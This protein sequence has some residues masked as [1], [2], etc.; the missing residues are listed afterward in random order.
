[1]NDKGVEVKGTITYSDLQNVKV[2]FEGSVEPGTYTIAV[3]TRSG[4]GGEYGV[5]RATR[6]VVVK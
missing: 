2:V 4:M 6:K 1:M 3:Y 5:K